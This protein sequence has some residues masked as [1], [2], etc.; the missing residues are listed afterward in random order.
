MRNT[1]PTQTR[2]TQ[3]FY[4]RVVAGLE[5]HAAKLYAAG[6]MADI[7]DRNMRVAIAYGCLEPTVTEATA[8]QSAG[9][10]SVFPSSATWNFLFL[11]QT[12]WLWDGAYRLKSRGRDKA[13]DPTG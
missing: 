1:P 5:R 7:P 10:V 9:F 11:N 13:L 12:D 2:A 4:T 6:D 8:W 3:D